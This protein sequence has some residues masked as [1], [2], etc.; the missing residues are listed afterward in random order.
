M[1]QS[2]E[3]DMVILSL[4]LNAEQE[5]GES[6]FSNQTVIDILKTIISLPCN[7]RL[8]YDSKQ[9]SCDSLKN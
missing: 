8:M 5:T 6:L 1:S 9:T 3:L 2:V 7:V 4:S